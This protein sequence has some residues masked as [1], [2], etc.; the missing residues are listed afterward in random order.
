MNKIVKRILLGLLIFIV[1]ILAAAVIIPIAFKGKIVEY[2]KKEANTKINATIDFDKDVSL[3]LF[4][5]FPNLTIGIKNLKLVNKAPFLGDT[6]ISASQ[7]EA[8]LDIMTVLKGEKIQIKKIQLDNPR[9]NAHVHKDGLANWSITFPSNDSLKKEGKDTSSNFKMG[10]QKYAINHGYIVYNDESMGM[11]TTL[12]DLNHSGSGDFTS[13]VF[14]L[15]TKT[16]IEKTTFTY[17]GVSYLSKVKTQLIAGFNI[18]MK[19]SKYTLKDN[20]LQLNGMTVNFSGFIAMPGSDIN[21][22]I[23]FKSKQTEF[24]SIL[25]L[26][27][28]IYSHD[29][30]KLK[31]SGTMAFSGDVKGTYNDKTMPGFDVN[32][33]VNN[34]FF[35]YP[36][37][38]SPVKDVNITMTIN[39]PQ[40]DM[41]N[42]VIN[43][44]KAHFAMADL[45]FDMHMLVKTPMTD[46]YVDGAMQGK[47]ILENLSKVVKLDQ[48]TSATGQLDVDLAVKGHV[49]TLQN[50]KYEDFDAKGK[51][52]ATN[53][54]YESKDIPEKVTVSSATLTFNPKNVSLSGCKILLGKSDVSLDGSIDNMLGYMFKKNEVLHGMMSMNS[55]FFDVNPWMKSSAPANKTD[56]ASAMTVVELPEN[57][58]FTFKSQMDHVVYDKFDI[59]KL[60]GMLVLKDKKLE[61]TKIGMNLLGATFGMDGFYDTKVLNEPLVNMNLDIKNLSIPKTF[62]NF[63][64]VQKFAPIAKNMTGTMDLR[65]FVDTKLDKAMNPVF[66]TLNAN[67]KL[68]IDRA[69]LSD[70]LPMKELASQL[71]MDKFNN[72][73]IKNI[74]P[75][76]VITNGRFSLKEPLKFNVDQIKGNVTGSNGLDKTLDYVVGMEIPTGDMGGQASSIINGLAGK[77]VGVTLPKTVTVN[78]LIGG[79]FDKPSVKISMKNAVNGIVDDLKKKA[80]EEF[81]KKKKE[82]EDKAKA[83]IDKQKQQLEAQKKQLEDQAKAK[84]DAL[85]KQADDEKK[86][87][88]EEAKKKADEQKNNLKDQA[89]KKLNGLFK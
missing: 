83:E 38:P 85:K 51:V 24:K 3:T 26:I 71:K 22:D 78:A 8:T 58:D 36:D 39:S 18:D 32:L 63:V 25:S 7:F 62:E 74:H 45:P 66:S 2:V 37:L 20:E 27:P 52:V 19:N 57:I 87:L 77:D 30:D 1:V 70:F 41:N 86:R 35:Q 68:D 55:S 69:T 48:G 12:V 34:G 5:S 54:G 64:T 50:K 42:M 29:F 4:S 40:G 10:L 14:D 28:A 73:V 84:A 11:S 59:T 79:T 80:Q 81:D 21:M 49:S 56:T 43:I 76:F 17:G 88:E 31:T 89:K 67:G 33:A 13:D 15:E 72:I 61:F 9:I 53:I 44:A 65:M 75:S 6:L 60:H 23:A 82:V 47:I 16:N 46:P